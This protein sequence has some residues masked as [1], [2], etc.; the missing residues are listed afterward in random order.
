MGVCRR[1]HIGYALQVLA[2][3]VLHCLGQGLLD[4]CRDRF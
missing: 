2:F 4:N 3:L 1:L